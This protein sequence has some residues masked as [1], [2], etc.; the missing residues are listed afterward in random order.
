MLSYTSRVFEN[1][2]EISGYPVIHLQMKS[3]TPDAAIIVYLLDIDENGR[4]TYL[5][6]GNFRIIHRKIS[7][8]DGP[9]QIQ[10]PNHSFLKKDACPLGKDETAVITFGLLPISALVKKGHR[11]RVSVAG[12]DNGT[13]AAIAEKDFPVFEIF[14]GENSSKIILPAKW[15][16]D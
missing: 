11:I 4:V 2:L 1:D 3:S 15:R 14:F 16:V 7:N 12:H 5:S 8:Q 9:Y 6:E 13:F 10:V